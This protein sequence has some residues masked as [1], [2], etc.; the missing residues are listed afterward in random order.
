MFAT[1]LVYKSRKLKTPGLPVA[2]PLIQVGRQYLG[3]LASTPLQARGEQRADRK[4]Y[5]EVEIKEVEMVAVDDF[6]DILQEEL[7]GRPVTDLD[8]LWC[9]D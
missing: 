8:S 6:D 4:Y 9:S 2:P 5:R 7:F 1:Q 3:T